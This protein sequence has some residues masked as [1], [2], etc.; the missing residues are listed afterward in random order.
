[1]SA[2]SSINSSVFEGPLVLGG[3]MI[4]MAVKQRIR[5][6]MFGSASKTRTYNLSVNSP[7]VAKSIEN[8]IFVAT[9]SPSSGEP[10][11]LELLEVAELH[12]A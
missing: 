1:M 10:L 9:Q 6:V 4:S 12:W 3:L 2:R 5:R 7:R 8:P 11:S